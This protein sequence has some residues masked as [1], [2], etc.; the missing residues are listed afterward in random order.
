MCLIGCDHFNLPPLQLTEEETEYKVVCVRHVLDS[1]LVLQF[2]CTNTV[3]EQ[4]GGAASWQ[5]ARGRPCRSGACRGVC[6]HVA[7]LWA[8][9]RLSDAAPLAVLTCCCLA[10]AT[11]VL[12]QVLEDVSVAVDLAEAVRRRGMTHGGLV[13]CAPL[14]S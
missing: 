12:A 5:A 8:W 13:V 10:V 11:H 14:Q 2:N 4:V 3:K 7:P 1:H 6:S 9:H